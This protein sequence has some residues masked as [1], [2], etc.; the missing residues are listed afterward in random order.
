MPRPAPARR[1]TVVRAG[2]G[3][4]RFAAGGRTLRHWS[5]RPWRSDVRRLT[6]AVLAASAAVLLAGCSG[7]GSIDWNQLGG[8][9]QQ[10]VDSARGAVDQAQA[11]ADELGA[12]GAEAKSAI[13]QATAA[14]D[15]AR[16]VAQQGKD[17]GE[18][19]VTKARSALDSAKQ[20]VDSAAEKAPD[21]LAGV[22]R[23][24]SDQLDKLA[25][26]L[27]DGLL[28]GPSSAPREPGRTPARAGTVCA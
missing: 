23:S 10:G 27:E 4:A 3:P 16:T 7:D 20:A 17:A 12:A 28:T 22:L 18:E 5:P 13:E 11:K 25:G 24:L 2:G 9:V 15:Q 21:Q 6:A 14:I 19:A 1:G 8:R 26:D